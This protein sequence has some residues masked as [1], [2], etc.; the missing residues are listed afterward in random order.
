[1]RSAS[2]DFVFRY[3]DFIF[4]FILHFWFN[5]W[6]DLEFHSFILLWLIFV[7]PVSARRACL[8]LVLT[9]V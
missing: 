8:R 6:I 3:S 5:E 1:M 2:T 4:Y 7:V 9:G